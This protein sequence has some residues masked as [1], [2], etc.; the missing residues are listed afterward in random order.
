M[1]T[2]GTSANHT[3]QV[4]HP[5]EA[6]QLILEEGGATPYLWEIEKI[7]DPAIVKIEERFESS[8]ETAMGAS[9]QKIFTLKAISPG[10]ATISIKH[11]D[12]WQNHVLENFK[13][14]ISVL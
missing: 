12:K 8:A 7:S 4:L 10:L 2:I 13:L 3:T 5:D 14:T 1:K 6:I 9:G 11:W